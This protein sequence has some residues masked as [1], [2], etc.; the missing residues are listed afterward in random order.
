MSGLLYDL[1][2]E[3]PG[4]EQH[5]HSQCVAAKNNS[6]GWEAGIQMIVSLG[7]QDPIVQKRK[8]RIPNERTWHE[9]DKHQKR[10]PTLLLFLTSG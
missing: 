6:G 1:K 2:V 4:L 7:L 8:R 10:G 5:T 3:D 9:T